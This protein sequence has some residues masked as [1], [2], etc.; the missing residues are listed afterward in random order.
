MPGEIRQSAFDPYREIEQHQVKMQQ[1]GKYGALVC[2]IGSMRDFNEEQKVTSLTLEHYPGMT[3]KHL[4]EICLSACRQW[5]LI[6]T[7][8]LHRVG[9]IK[10][11]EPIVLVAVWAAHRQA[12]FEACR[13]IMEDLKSKAPFWKQETTEQGKRWVEKNT[14][15]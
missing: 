12:A 7:L 2:F 4:D 9:A 11:A 6:E 1:G 8:V 10:I 3:E 15:G 14:P 13:F 5:Q